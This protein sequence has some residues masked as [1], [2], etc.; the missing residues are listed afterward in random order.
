[1]FLLFK[2]ISGSSATRSLPSLN[3]PGPSFHHPKLGR[4]NTC[5]GSVRTLPHPERLPSK[6]QLFEQ[7]PVAAVGESPPPIASVPSPRP[8][9]HTDYTRLFSDINALQTTD[10]AHYYAQLSQILQQK[11]LSVLGNEVINREMR[12]SL[13]VFDPKFV[14]L[15]N[16]SFPLQ[17]VQREDK[18]SVDPPIP[19]T[20]VGHTEL[21]NTVAGEEAGTEEKVVL[22]SGSYGK[23][24]PGIHLKDGQ[25][26]EVAVKKVPLSTPSQRNGLL[27]LLREIHIGTKI[28]MP[29]VARILEAG[30]TVSS[31]G[32]PTAYLT[33]PFY[34]GKELYE[35]IMDDSL[36]VPA[37]NE[38][39]DIV[40]KVIAALHEM[41]KKGL[42][43]TDLKAENV[44]YDP[45]TKEVTI[46][47]LGGAKLKNDT[48]P[49]CGTISAMA[50]ERHQKQKPPYS[51]AS[52]IFSLGVFMI[53]I[54][55]WGKHPFLGDTDKAS[56]ESIVAYAKNPSAYGP[57]KPEALNLDPR[58]D[59]TFLMRLLAPDPAE[60]P[61][62]SEVRA[63]M[64][65]VLA[66]DQLET[67]L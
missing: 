17:L 14:E 13:S 2:V 60:R 42:H 48:A 65:G 52:G 62:L 24:R 15:F 33:M 53:D 46:V 43:Y 41:A 47:D 37:L 45:V 25:E 26:M 18:R 35:L 29:G 51:D 49:C 21:H 59:Y 55:T 5:P 12:E 34:P 38:R 40:N 32:I 39:V 67:V 7:P 23:V 10:L 6:A 8:G 19:N 57:L 61:P 56:L 36:P 50:P 66:T 28:N 20:R 27:F 30:L 64:A 1:M 16:A 31:K 4:R 58:L 54:L 9:I 11:L 44:L 63:Y 3:L 22:G